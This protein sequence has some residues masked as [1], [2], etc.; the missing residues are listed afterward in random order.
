MICIRLNA[1]V[2]VFWGGLITLLWFIP[3]FILVLIF[4]PGKLAG[5]FGGIGAAGPWPVMM[6]SLFKMRWLFAIIILKKDQL[7]ISGAPAGI[8]CFPLAG[9]DSLIE[10]RFLGIRIIEIVF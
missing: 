7:V 2:S 8:C 1:K 3:W 4:Y 5:L 10:H 9:I 6:L